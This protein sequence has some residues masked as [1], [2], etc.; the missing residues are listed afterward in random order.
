[1]TDI[2]LKT[3]GSKNY[4]LALQFLIVAIM[5]LS[6]IALLKYIWVG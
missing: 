6:I 5:I 4:S 3:S 2:I 1:M